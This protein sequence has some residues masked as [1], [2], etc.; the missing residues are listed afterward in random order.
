MTHRRNLLLVGLL[1]L[2][3]VT[4]G[5]CGGGDTPSK[6][7]EK[8]FTAVDKGDSTTLEQVAGSGSGMLAS[9]LGKMAVMKYGMPKKYAHTINGES[10]TVTVTYENGQ[11]EQFPLNKVNG[12]WQMRPPG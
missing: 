9:P 12:K 7:V 6:T 11:T 4:V 5:G 10:A 8:F 3:L 1:S 2:A